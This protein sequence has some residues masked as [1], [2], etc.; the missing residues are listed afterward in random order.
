MLDSSNNP[1]TFPPWIRL[2]EKKLREHI[3]VWM[4]L[5]I[6]FL[7][8]ITNSLPDHRCS[9]LPCSWLHQHL[10]QTMDPRILVHVVS[11]TSAHTCLI[12]PSHGNEGDWMRAVCQLQGLDGVTKKNVSSASLTF[13]HLNPVWLWTQFSKLARR[14]GQVSLPVGRQAE[15][16]AALSLF[17]H[18]S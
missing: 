1:G 16:T 6:W 15:R 12:A 7:V 5:W 3:F 2:L 14:K 13:P 17:S 8:L 18:H 9:S 4:N 10:A 11:L